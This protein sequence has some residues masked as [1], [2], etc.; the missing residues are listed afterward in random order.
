VVSPFKGMQLGPTVRESQLRGEAPAYL[1]ACGLALR[2][3]G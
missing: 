3:F 1:V 2:R